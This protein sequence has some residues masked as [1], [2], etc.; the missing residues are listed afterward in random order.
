MDNVVESAKDMLGFPVLLGRVGTRQSKMNGVMSI[1]GEGDVHKLFAIVC[2]N[3]LKGTLKLSANISMKRDKGVVNIGFPS[4]RK[5]PT[6]VR[7]IIDND[8]VILKTRWT[9]NRRCP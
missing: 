4:K 5:G 8:K 9:L 7:E 3:R 6:K 1:E 2:L